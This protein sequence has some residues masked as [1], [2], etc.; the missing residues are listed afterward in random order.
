MPRPDLD[1][2]WDLWCQEAQGALQTPDEP[3]LDAWPCITSVSDMIAGHPEPPVQDPQQCNNHSGP[4]SGPCRPTTCGSLQWSLPT[5]PHLAPPP[6]LTSSKHVEQELRSQ[7]DYIK[8]LETLLTGMGLDRAGAA[9]EHKPRST[10]PAAENLALRQ[11]NR[12]LRAKVGQLQR[13]VEQAHARVRRA[14]QINAEWRDHH[15]KSR[16]REKAQWAQVHAASERA[17]RADILK[18]QLRRANEQLRVRSHELTRYGE[19]IAELEAT[20]MAL[21]ESLAMSVRELGHSAFQ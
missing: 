8:E 13:Q 21:R 19:R 4:C 18:Q 12:V 6:A 11:A 5:T 3:P 9:A 1:A 17:Q 16:Q 20:V 15:G 14:E 2:Q 7:G 10:S